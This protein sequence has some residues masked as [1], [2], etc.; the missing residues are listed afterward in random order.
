MSIRWALG[1]LWRHCN[2]V[3]HWMYYLSPVG[4]A[5]TTSSLST[6]HLASICF[7]KTTASRDE[8]H[9]SFGV[10][11]TYIRDFTVAHIF[12]SMIAMIMNEL[13]SWTRTLNIYKQSITQCWYSNVLL[14]LLCIAAMLIFFCALLNFDTLYLFMCFR[15]VYACRGLWPKSDK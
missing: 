6:W 9:L 2:D 8:K 7:T 5:P 10:G 13:Y 11:A 12:L 15:T 14:L 1:A 3:K 4:A